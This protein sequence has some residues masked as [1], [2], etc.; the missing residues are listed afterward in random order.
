MSNTINRPI[1]LENIPVR[2][3]PVDPLSFFRAEDREGLVVR[4]LAPAVHN[5]DNDDE[6]AEFVATLS[7]RNTEVDTSSL[8]LIN[9]DVTLDFNFHGFTPLT[10]PANPTAE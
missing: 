9:D 10:S 5:H 3:P 2:N 1:R 7:S 4:S 6:N 8:V